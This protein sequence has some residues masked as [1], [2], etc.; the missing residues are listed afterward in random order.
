MDL[1]TAVMLTI[2]LAGD[3]RQHIPQPRVILD[4]R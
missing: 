1:V 2:K 3:W 4:V